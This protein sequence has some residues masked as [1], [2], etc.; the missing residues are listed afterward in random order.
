MYCD[1]SLS[2]EYQEDR[3][4]ALERLFRA[5]Q[6]Y[7]RGSPSSLL[8]ALILGTSENST[9]YEIKD[10]KLVQIADFE[11]ELIVLV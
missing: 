2:E 6:T 5:M 4:K 7:L 10:G 11:N 8:Q 1:P 9:I 3:K